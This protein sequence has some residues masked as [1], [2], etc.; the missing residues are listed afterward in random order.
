MKIRLNDYVEFEKNNIKYR[1]NVYKINDD[2]TFCVKAFLKNEIV[3][4]DNL[5]ESEIT[6]IITHTVLCYIEKEESYLMLLRNKREDDMNKNKWLGLG[7]HI[8]YGESPDEALIREVKEESGISLFEYQLRGIIY[9][10]NDNYTEVMHLYTSK[11]F[12]GELKECD[13]GTLRWVKKSQILDLELWEGDK[14]FL[15]L[16]IENEPYFEMELNYKNDKLISVNKY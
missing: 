4:F 5:K 6:R 3:N 14:S 11:A 12:G 2:G 9:F 13:E 7:G 1:A 8:E 15:P 10:N 16:L